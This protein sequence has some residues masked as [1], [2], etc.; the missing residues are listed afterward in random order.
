[1]GIEPI[2]VGCCAAAQRYIPEDFGLKP[3]EITELQTLD[4]RRLVANDK[5]LSN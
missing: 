2:T 3:N 1:M 4:S 5:V